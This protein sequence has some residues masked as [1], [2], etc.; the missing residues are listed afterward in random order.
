MATNW[1]R[2]AGNRSGS[3]SSSAAADTNA[4]LVDE[5]AGLLALN[6]SLGSTGCGVG[7]DAFG[8]PRA[9]EA[10]IP[11]LN[12]AVGRTPKN[13]GCQSTRSASLPGSTDPTSRSI[14]CATAGQIVY[15]AT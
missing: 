14:P 12:T 9:A 13:A 10:A 1:R 11:P 5:A 15:L 6:P 3:P 4:T 8:S 2:T 7:T